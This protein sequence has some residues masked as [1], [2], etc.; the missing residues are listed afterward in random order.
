MAEN[1]WINT[2]DRLKNEHGKIEE[3]LRGKKIAFLD[4]PAYFNVGD[5]LIYLG[6]EA[7]FKKYSINVVYKSD[8]KNINY[9]KLKDIDVIVFQGGGNFG[10]LYPL[11][12]NMRERI[13]EKFP[14]KRI[15]CLPQT[16]Y[17]SCNNK[18]EKSIEKFNSHPDFHFF[19]RDERSLGIAKQFSKNT[20]LMP[21]MAHSLH[22]VVDKLEV[23]PSNV[24]PPSIL[25]LVRNDVESSGHS[26]NYV[27]KSS[28]DWED[29]ITSNDLINVRIYNTLANFS[30]TQEKAIRF[31]DKCAKDLCFRSINYF[32][33]FSVIHTD[34]LH[35]LILSSLLGKETYM[36]DNSYGKNSSYYDL[37]L[38]NIP[39][40]YKK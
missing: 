19:V 24:R 25:S 28:F 10:D 8:Y 3:L 23:G 21:D 15:V 40:I 18:M 4:V 38:R 1:I 7:F 31:W 39:F 5:L 26:I 22:P 32:R 29:I 35:G 14:S 20:Y 37:W 16:I 13:A 30:F 12:Q 6:T 36:Y 33:G 27:N 11:L 9:S 34:R 17:F 2:M